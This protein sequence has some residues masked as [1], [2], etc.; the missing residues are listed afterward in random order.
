MS[1]GAPIDGATGTQIT[2]TASGAYT[3]MVTA[4]NGCSA[5]ADPA[6]E[7]VVNPL[8]VAEVSADGST[9]FCAGG[10]VA[11]STTGT[12]GSSYQWYLNGNLVN[13]ATD[14]NWTA[15]TSGSYT[16]VII[17]AAGCASDASEAVEVTV[18]P[19]PAAN[20]S[21]TEPTTFCEGNGVT[22][23]A[24]PIDGAEYQW[25]LDGAVIDGATSAQLTAT[26]SGAYTVMVTAANGCSAM[27]DL[28]IDVLVN[29][30]PGTPVITNDG[31]ALVASGTGTY[32]WFLDG[33]SIDGA[34]DA[35]WVPVQNGSYT[36]EISDANG[37]SST[38][39]AYLFLSTGMDAQ[40]PLELLVMPNPSDG[41]FVI[42]QPASQGRQ[43]EILDATGKRLL[44][45]RFDGLR[46]T[47]N[48]R[49]AE[50][51]IYFLRVLDDRNTPVL[52]IAITR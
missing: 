32:Q 10:A 25:M 37:C 51:G 36:V 22:L 47:V 24:D 3:V 18:D 2:V 21:A 4:A 6:I 28:A 35:A 30:L 14:A 46:T 48:M 43:F 5:L 12:T 13:D 33:T 38:S 27:G 49:N 44:T 39:E 15:T 45:D 29:P 1:D 52:R 50:Q 41:T 11:L 8:P 16:V 9:T 7:V 34:T 31:E 20:V 40:T 17:S 42:Q 19:V 26:A 23:I